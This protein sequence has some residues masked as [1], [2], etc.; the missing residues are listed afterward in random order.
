MWRLAGDPVNDILGERIQRVAQ[1]TTSWPPVRRPSRTL[2]RT[3]VGGRW[4]PKSRPALTLG[5]V[6]GGVVPL[7]AS[8]PVPLAGRG[9]GW[10]GSTR[11]F[12]CEPK[13]VAPPHPL[14]LPVEGR[15]ISAA[16]ESAGSGCAESVAKMRQGARPAYSQ[17]VMAAREAAIQGT[18]SDGSGRALEPQVTP[19]HDVVLESVSDA[20]KSARSGCGVGCKARQGARPA[21]LRFGW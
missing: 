3:A 12:T 18:G 21:R 20:S 16:R 1:F 5:G 4:S 8:L 10:A 9:R 13:R 2:A 19:G 14:P 15:G 6:R 11:N 17:H 7:D